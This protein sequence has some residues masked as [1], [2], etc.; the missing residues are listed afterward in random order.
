MRE[1]KSCLK[2]GKVQFFSEGRLVLVHMVLMKG[3]EVD[4]AKVEVI[5]KFPPPIFVKRVVQPQP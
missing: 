1:N 5:E 3:F 2:F 4:R